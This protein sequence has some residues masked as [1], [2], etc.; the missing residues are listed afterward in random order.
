M[1]AGCNFLDSPELR[2]S[3][4]YNVESPELAQQVIEYMEEGVRPENAY[5]VLLDEDGEL[6]WVTEVDGNEVRY[7]QEPESTFG[8]RFM[9]GFIMMLPV[10][11][12]L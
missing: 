12:Q 11:H 8:Q 6:Y 10:E 5:R 4:L 2:V 7:T 1:L 9:S 3:R